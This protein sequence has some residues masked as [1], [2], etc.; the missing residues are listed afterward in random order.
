MS[1][2]FVFSGIF[3]SKLDYYPGKLSLAVL[4]FQYNTP[5]SLSCSWDPH[6]HCVFQIGSDKSFVKR[7]SKEFSFRAKHEIHANRS[8]QHALRTVSFDLPRY[9]KI[10]K[11]SL[12]LIFFKGLFLGL[13]FGGAYVRREIC[14]SKSIGLALFLEGN[15]PFFFV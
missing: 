11:I 13:I 8:F 12:G 14:V 6:L 15:S 10:P 1:L 4:N 7:W 3:N 2:T 9:R 5:V